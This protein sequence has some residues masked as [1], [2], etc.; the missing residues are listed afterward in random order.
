MK[1]KPQSLSSTSRSIRL[2][3]ELLEERRMLAFSVTEAELLLP[4]SSLHTLVPYKSSWRFVDDGSD[5][6][7]QWKDPTFDD[8]AWKVAVE[9]L[10]YA[11]ASSSAT[12]L[13]QLAGR[14]RCGPAPMCDADNHATTYFRH[15][16]PVVDPQRVI[17]LSASIWRNQSTA[18]YL[19]GI[20]VFRD[21]TLPSDSTFSSFASQ[22][23]Q[24]GQTVTFSIDPGLLEPGRN[25]LAAEVHLAAP[26]NG[27]LVF[28]TELNAMVA[29]NP[30]EPM[31]L[32]LALSGPVQQ[33]TVDAADLSV[34]GHAASR[35]TIVDGNTIQFDLPAL[36]E[37]AALVAS[38][39]AGALAQ[40]D[41]DETPIEAFAMPFRLDLSAQ[42]LVK[43]NPRLQPGNMPLVPFA[44]SE[45]DR[46]DVLWQ[47]VPL[48]NL[49]HDR[50][51]VQY[52]RAGSDGPWQTATL[53]DAIDTGFGGRVIHSATI[54]G[55]EYDADYEYR[56]RHL[57]EDGALV[58]T[59][60]YPFH[61]RLPAGSDKPFTF[62]AYGDSAD[63][64]VV[65]NFR[66]VQGRINRSPSAFSVSLGD[67]VY[68][69]GRHAE[70]DAR[71]DPWVN[72]EAALWIASHIDYA[73]IGNH[74]TAL[75]ELGHGR[76]RPYREYFS[77]PRPQAQVNAPAQ[78]PA[79]EPAEHNYSFD[80]GNVHFVTFD[81][82][83]LCCAERLDGLIRWMEADLAA[84]G[85][86][87][88]I[89][90]GHHPVA[91]VPD[92]PESPRDNYYQQIV[93]RLGAAGV[94]VF[95]M[96]H[97]HTFSWT[98]PLLGQVDGVASFIDD[99]D[100]AYSKGAGLVQ[101]VAGVG[102]GS[103]RPGSYSSPGQQ[104]IAAGFTT[105]TTPPVQFGYA[106]FDITP[107]ALKV[108][109][110]A[111]ADGAVI[112]SFSI[113]DEEDFRIFQQGVG[114]YEGTRDT[115]LRQTL[116][117]TNHA[118]TPLLGVV[119]ADT[120]AMTGASHTLLRFDDIFGD[121]AGQIPTG[122]TIHA[123]RLELQVMNGGDGIRLYR[124]L[125]PW[126]D[127][128]TWSSAV[129]GIQ[130]DGQEAGI[131]PDGT[132]AA[133]VFGTLALDV[134]SSIHTWALD[135][136]TNY[137]WALL[138][139]G[140]DAVVLGSAEGLAPRLVVQ[141]SAPEPD[142][143][144]ATVG[145]VSPNPRLKMVDEV[146]VVF[147]EPV[148]GFDVGDMQL[149][150]NGTKTPLPASATLRSL[151]NVSWSVGNLG[152]VT[153][154][155]GNYQLRIVDRGPAIQ[156]TKGIRL[157][158][159]AMTSWNDVRQAGDANLDGAFDQEDVVQVL[160]AG[161]KYLSGQPAS[162]AEGD[163][164]GDGL[165]DPR[166]IVAALQLGTYLKGP[167]VTVDLVFDQMGGA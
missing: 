81:T 109:Y 89:V 77:N 67:N 131:Q 156:N 144:R 40:G 39:A 11:S 8:S 70:S 84:S 28:S 65:G 102:G 116:P 47:T 34:N 94:D 145:D 161:G 129:E 46:V 63:I 17:G 48:G 125:Q 32:R 24:D 74:E 123:A 31:R 167:Y 137:G 19:N 96:G 55:L 112:D 10:G 73:A 130:A 51:T 122:A 52:R 91:F 41:A 101:V 25:V 75:F 49:T 134:T 83:S 127:T 133:A 80:Y 132:A 66:S 35:V 12:L 151:D 50:F 54:D 141:L 57:R 43:H 98:K 56:V 128:T 124:M 103:V 158:G 143:P 38:I 7:T 113:V 163:F 15:T 165:F 72:P 18:V 87:W 69:Y 150:R 117:F 105:Q 136:S 149:M 138:P 4:A 20:E 157:V 59:Y 30:L 3:A 166:D 160:Q 114:G 33:T 53:N 82:N 111:A 90:Y 44:G 9:P 104:A 155:P 106:Q 78:P 62:S 121:G 108:S 88:K 45:R 162:W 29:T 85:A 1:R 97:S 68:T 86:T 93:S 92:K 142:G 100:K 147:S 27:E 119:E 16:F 146:R 99:T 6:G 159:E 13:L 126:S 71:F 110:V 79:S 154:Q 152:D 139:M 37:P 42:Y 107:T 148:S 118:V 140:K 2:G 64:R 61:T 22:S 60:Q 115:T 135:P 21:A 58:N 153:D 164:T 120:S 76:G 5:R 36:D 23:L 26:T 95:L 14:V